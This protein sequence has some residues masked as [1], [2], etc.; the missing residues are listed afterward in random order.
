MKRFFALIAFGYFALLNA[1]SNPTIT[2]SKDRFKAYYDQFMCAEKTA[3]S[4]I[5]SSAPCSSLGALPDPPPATPPPDPMAPTT[6]PSGM[7]PIV[8]VNNSGVVDDEV[9]I[10]VEGRDPT[11]NDQCFVNFP[12]PSTGIGANV[13]PLT[14]SQNG[15]TYTVALGSLP[16]NS[17]GNGRVIYLPQISSFIILMSLNSKLNVPVV[18]AGIQNPAFDTP[19]DANHNFDIIWD[20]FEGNWV[21]GAMPAV[22]VDAT[23]VSF[24]GIPY[25]TY[26]STPSA[27]SNFNAGLSQTRSAI[28]SYMQRVFPQSPL[29]QRMRNGA[30]WS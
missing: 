30:T 13:F 2:Y 16:L 9:F 3:L 10:L 15:M 14:T 22:D 12:T 17:D 21:V 20:Q 28:L 23:A 29:L 27:N 5:I 8:F 19:N 11:T 6:F 26:I 1:S 25:Y 18:A 4:E 7:L 24:F